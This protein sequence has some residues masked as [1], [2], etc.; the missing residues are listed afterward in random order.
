MTVAELIKELQQ[1]PVDYEVFYEGGDYKEDW[2]EINKVSVSHK[3]ILGTPVG[4]YLE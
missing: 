3:S 4:I 2:R 1:F